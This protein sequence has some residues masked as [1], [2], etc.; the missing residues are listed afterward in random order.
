MWYFFFQKVPLDKRSDRVKKEG[1]ITQGNGCLKT[2]HG[3]HEKHKEE[4][5][6]KI[7]LLIDIKTR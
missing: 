2:E 5:N 7:L 4:L 3:K 1:K 6:N